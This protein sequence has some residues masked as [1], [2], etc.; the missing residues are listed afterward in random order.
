MQDQSK[1]LFMYQSRDDDVVL[2]AD[3]EK[4]K[5]ALPNASF[6]E[7]D[8]RGHFR[9]DNFPEIVREIKKAF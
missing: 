9:Q 4:Y 2:F 3:F 1:K 8:N 5:K 7:F 6:R